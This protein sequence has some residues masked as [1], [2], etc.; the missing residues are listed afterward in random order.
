VSRPHRPKLGQHFLSDPHYRARIA[1]SLA[2]RPDDLVIEVGAGNGAMT[3]LLARR[4]RRVIAVELDP[5]LVQKLK[6]KTGEDSRIEVLHADILEVD[7]AELC[8][9]H[10]FEKCLVFGNL[11]YYITS[12]IISRL[13][14]YRSRI[15]AMS[16]LVQREVALRLTATPGRRAYGYLSVMAQTFWQPRVAFDVPPGAFSPSPKVYSSLVNFAAQPSPAEGADQLQERAGLT[17]GVASLSPGEQKKFL[18]FV[19]LCF[20]HKRRN[21]VSNLAAKFPRARVER[22]IARLE[23]PRTVRAEELTAGQLSSL[24]QRLDF[25]LEPDGESRS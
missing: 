5:A 20:T 8:R 13:T 18:E 7:I 23:L 1:E 2:L 4:A 19:K 22:E 17:H 6:E 9:K 14:A 15:R 25:P 12:P 11:P 16:L 10:E 3:E 24:H 21:L